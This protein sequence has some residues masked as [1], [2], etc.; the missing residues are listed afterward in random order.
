MTEAGAASG[1]GYLRASHAD[2]EQVIEVLKTAFVQGRLTKAELDAR[3]D[4]AF[5]SRVRAELAA[6]TSDLPAGPVAPP[7]QA[8]QSRPQQQGN[9]TL[10]KGTVAITAAT[11]LT[12]C[13]WAAAAS[14]TNAVLAVLVLTVTVTWVGIVLLVGAV[15]LDSA[16]RNVHH[17]PLPPRRPPGAGGSPPRRAAPPGGS[18]GPALIDQ[19]PQAMAETAPRRPSRA[20]YCPGCA[21]EAL[22]RSRG[23][24][25]AGQLR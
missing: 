14:T 2:R 22:V 25:A 16:Q 1:R 15:M 23:R 24:L 12:G 3:V 17:G 7:R 11:A 4:Q 6:V 8:A 20:R 13:L 21:A 18:G 5:A 9:P 19:A 10:R